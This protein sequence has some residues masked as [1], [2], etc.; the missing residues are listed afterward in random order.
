[1]TTF[2]WVKM[3]EKNSNMAFCPDPNLITEPKTFHIQR[4]S[5]LLGL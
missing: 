4:I 5:A 3:R 2:P 1:M